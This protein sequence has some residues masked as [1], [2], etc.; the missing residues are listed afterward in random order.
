VDPLHAVRVLGLRRDYSYRPIWEKETVW[1]M[2]SGEG[3]QNRERF[4]AETRELREAANEQLTIEP[5]VTLY[6]RGDTC[7]VVADHTCRVGLEQIDGAAWAMPEIWQGC[8]I[9]RREENRYIEARDGGGLT[10]AA[11]RPAPRSSH[12][13]EPA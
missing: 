13:P 11:P 7:V 3:I 10:S 8:W 9:H 6:R 12:D 5:G 1:R 4:E 2:T